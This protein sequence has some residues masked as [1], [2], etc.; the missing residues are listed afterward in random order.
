V[1]LYAT[2]EIAEWLSELGN[3]LRFVLITSVAEVKTADDRPVDALP[4]E[5][6]GLWIDVR[7]SHNQKCVRCWHRRA[8]VGSDPG[9]PELCS[10]CITNIDG[11]GE[12]RHY[13]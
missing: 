4:T 1:F 6:V 8:D 7:P 5:M 12:E 9:H 13:A 3:E 2:P 11:P 10:R